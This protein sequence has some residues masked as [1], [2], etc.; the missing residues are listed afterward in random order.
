MIDEQWAVS[1]NTWA[2]YLYLVNVHKFR[3]QT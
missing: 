2:M 3:I 1:G